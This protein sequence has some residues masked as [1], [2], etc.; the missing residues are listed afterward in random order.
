[1]GV[2]REGA[3]IGGRAVLVSLRATTSDRCFR[4][5]DVPS[6]GNSE[7][8]NGGGGY[9]KG[10]FHQ[11]GAIVPLTRHRELKSGSRATARYTT[12]FRLCAF[13]E[14]I[15][16]RSVDKDQVNPIPHRP[17]RSTSY[18]SPQSPIK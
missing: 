14:L 1:M 11:S 13:I 17:H 4:F 16:P 8:R 7:A 9:S 3:R 2:I 12:R 15:C 18:P 5:G 10:G 6:G